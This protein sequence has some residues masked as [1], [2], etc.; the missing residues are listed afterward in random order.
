[1]YRSPADVL[2]TITA[3]AIA[4][5]ASTGAQAQ[6][7]TVDEQQRLTAR[8][9]LEKDPGSPVV[10]NAAGSVTVVQ[11]YDYNCGQC[12]RVAQALAELIRR[13][14][15]VRV[16]FKEYPILS[17]SSVLAASAALAASK[18][19]RFAAFH[20]GLM[21]L[22]QIDEAGIQALSARLLINQNQLLAD[23]RSPEIAT[24]IGRHHSLGGQLGI[25]GT[26]AFVI[27]KRLVTGAI[28]ANQMLEL[29]TLERTNCRKP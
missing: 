7:T 10:G 4:T 19:G 12:K 25:S 6:E 29:V 15:D 8:S 18:P 28:E 14:S 24:A 26:P 16:V 11:F 13:D 22:Q 21:Q 5:L 17:P 2:A 20:E 9:Q 23:L 27:G 3:L 1:L